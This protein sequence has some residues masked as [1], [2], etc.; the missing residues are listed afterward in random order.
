MPKTI[1]SARGR[2]RVDKARTSTRPNTA[3][4]AQRGGAGTDRQ[5][6]D[7]SERH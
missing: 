5:I 7:F 6:F 3:Q 2:S 1:F 4:I